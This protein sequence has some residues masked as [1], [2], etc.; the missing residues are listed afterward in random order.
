MAEYALLKNAKLQYS[1][2]VTELTGAR[3]STSPVGLPV[4]VL[5]TPLVQR[6]LS[7]N[8]EPFKCPYRCLRSCNPAKSLFCI[9]QALIATWRG[10]VER[11]LYMVGCNVE[12][13]RK[14]YPVKEFV[15]TL[16]GE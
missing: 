6:V 11:G 14:I 12:A 16:A 3:Y 9:A 15:D 13:C 5:N 1:V 7:G 2:S 4:R 8:R 10:D